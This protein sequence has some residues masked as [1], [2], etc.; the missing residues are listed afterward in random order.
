[1]KKILIIALMIAGNSA[2]ATKA[3][4]MALGRAAHLTD[5]QT[6]LSIPSDVLLV[7]ESMEFNF[8][9]ASTVGS[10]ADG[11]MVKAM[12]EA[13]LG[14]FL[15]AVDSV[16]QS[17]YLGVENPFSV[18]YGA[19]AGDMTWGVSFSYADSAKK[20]D[21]AV[22]TDDKKQSFMSL[23]GSV[24]MGDTTI[25]LNLGLGDTATGN[26]TVESYKYTNSPMGLA[27]YHKVSDWT[28]YGSYE[29]S[30][31]KVTE[32][33][34]TKTTSSE[35]TLGGVHAMKSEGADF[36]YGV[37]Y[38]MENSKTGSAKSDTTSLPFIIGIEADAAS[39]LTLRGSVTQN[40]LLGGTK[41]TTPDSGLNSP[42]HST[43]VNAGMGFK[44][45][46]SVLDITLTAANTA[47]KEGQINGSSFGANAGL[48]YLF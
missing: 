10:D 32:A 39:W 27:V 37:A 43:T 29:A 44:F 26:G 47:G 24:G 9:P 18:V 31:K 3:R 45:T 38:K 33:A 8:G 1:M 6:V 25:A 34:E 40:V 12:G 41:T 4:Y 2:F 19:K 13:R 17:T 46:K 28:V 23:N 5:M 16:R 35:I 48:T 21:P 15:G 42:N 7:P 36:F 20:V 14:F 30:T 22:A 11:G